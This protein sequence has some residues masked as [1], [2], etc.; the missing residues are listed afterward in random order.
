VLTLPPGNHFVV[1]GVGA[2]PEPD[3]DFAFA[4]AKRP[5]AYSYSNRICLIPMMNSFEVKA[6][7]MLVLHPKLVILF[8]LRLDSGGKFGEKRAEGGGEM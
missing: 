4:N 8:R 1:V 7:M 3:N 2:N 5:P 6:W